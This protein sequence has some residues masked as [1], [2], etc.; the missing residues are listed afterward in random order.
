MTC[1]TFMMLSAPGA[2]PR[3]SGRR[4]LA[5]RRIQAPAPKACVLYLDHRRRARR[6]RH[7]HD[8]DC[9]PGLRHRTERDPTDEASCHSRLTRRCRHGSAVAGPGE[10]CALSSRTTLRKCDADWRCRRD[11]RLS[12]NCHT[13]AVKRHRAARRHN[14]DRSRAAPA[15]R[16]FRRASSCTTLEISDVRA[17]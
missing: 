15:C 3:T 13:S 9:W 4:T 14:F 11:R 7:H 5:A 12:A 10:R 17:K 16:Q 1:V 8:S 6:V 2:G